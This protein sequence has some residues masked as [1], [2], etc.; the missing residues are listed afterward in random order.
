MNTH[1]DGHRKG[2]SKGRVVMLHASLG[3]WVLV[4]HGGEESVGAQQLQFAVDPPH[5][6][7]TVLT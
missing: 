4:H 7:K 2:N 6:L 3:S 5:P 1:D